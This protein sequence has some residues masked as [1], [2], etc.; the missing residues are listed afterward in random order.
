MACK[1]TLKIN[2]TGKV[3]TF[4][5]EK[6]LDNYLLSNYTEFEGM[7]DHTFRFSKDYI[8]ML[9]TE[10]VKSQDKLDKDRKLAYEKAKARNAKNDDTIVVKGQGEM[11]D[12]IE[13]EETYSDGFISVLK[14]LSRQRGT[15]APLINAFSREG[16][17]RNTRIDRSQGKPEDVSPEEWLKQVDSSIDQDFEYWDYLQEIGRGFHLVM[18]TVINSNFDI[19]ADMV[20]SVISKKFERDFL[21]GKNLSTLNG[22]STGALMSFIKG[23]TALKK[24]II[25]NS[26]RGRKFKKFYTE[27]V[28]DHDGGPDA[29]L[30]GKIDL[31]A[32]FEDNEGNQSVEI[33]DLKLATKPQD[34]WDADKKNTIQYQLGF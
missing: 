22:V 23:I 12:V 26:G 33:Y 29:K 8:T 4:N 1:Y 7:V 24:S 11:T 6:E 16:Y 34:R 25:L 21:G 9:D 14:F 30:R 2:S 28:V 13:N 31:L 32:V 5:S 10:Q 15:S 19:S 3:L 27:Y 20:D 18:D 17:K